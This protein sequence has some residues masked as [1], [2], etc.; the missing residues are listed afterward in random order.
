MRDMSRASRFAA[1]LVLALAPLVPASA[2]PVVLVS[3]DALSPDYVL[4]ADELGLKVPNL[5]RMMRE[6]SYA[7][8]VRGVVPTITCPSHATLVTGVTPAVHRVYGNEPWKTNGFSSA[9]CTFDSDIHADTLYA[10]AARAGIRSASVGWLNTA[11]SRHIAYNLPHVEPYESEVT[12]NYQRALSRPEG[13]LESLEARLGSYYQDGSEA[14]S[15][16]RLQFAAEIMKRH[17]PGFM[18][19]HMIAVDHAAHAHGPWSEAAKRAVEHEDAVLGQ[20]VDVALANDPDTVIVVASDHGQAPVT[21]SLNLRIAFVKAGLVELA[22]PVAGRAVQVKSEKVRIGGGASVPVMLTDP[23]DTATRARVSKVL[24]QLA[25]NPANGIDRIVE[26]ADLA[27]LGSGWNEAAFVV[28]MKPGTVIGSDYR[29]QL[30]VKRAA[31]TGTHGYLPEQSSMNAAFFVMGAGIQSGQNLGLIDMTQVAPTVA[32]ALGVVLKDARA[33]VLPVFAAPAGAALEAGMGRGGVNGSGFETT[34]VGYDVN[35]EP[36]FTL[37]A[38]LDA[39]GHADLITVNRGSLAADTTPANTISVLYGRG[40]GTFEP[41]VD[42]TVGHGPYMVT[43]GDLNEDGRKDIIVANFQEFGDNHIT[44]LL[45]AGRRRYEA[46]PYITLPRIPDRVVGVQSYASPGVTSLSVQD[47]DGDGHLDIIAVGYTNDVL[48]VLKGRGDGGFDLARTYQGEQFGYG[49]RD[50]KPAD[51]NQDGIVD[52]V[53]TCYDS[54]DTYVLLGKGDLTFEQVWRHHIQDVA[55][56]V[57]VADFNSDGWLDL[58]VGYYESGVELFI[59]DASGRGYTSG[60]IWDSDQFHNVREVQPHDFNV[61]GHMDVAVA[62]LKT[63]TISLLYG[64]GNHSPGRYF[65]DPLPIPLEGGARH[66]HV[67]D[68]NEDGIQDMAVTRINAGD[69]TILRGVSQG[70][71]Q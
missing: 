7:T 22:R 34:G 3:I 41:K 27:T 48:Y 51:F 10:A 8:G 16:K 57:N 61:D 21:Q 62:S 58:V 30:L 18:M 67:D 46:I 9:L 55:Y 69:V 19:F 2:A 28:G 15:E 71:R 39:D 43:L 68:F 32:R 59:N 70:A 50:I 60:G 65:S 26:G 36:Y 20:I 29:G 5:R 47:M 52:F 45:D 56:H 40:D 4:K 14:G 63:S 64:T 25:A 54:G 1:A 13:L 23:Q 42:Y 37:G 35:K 33:A 12:V 17:K 31:V 44:L 11:G 24:H 38:D 6:G 49:I 53:V 66:V